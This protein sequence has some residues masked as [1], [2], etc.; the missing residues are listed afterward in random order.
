MIFKKLADTCREYENLKLDQKQ[1]I[2]NHEP[3][4]NEYYNGSS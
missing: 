1:D 2:S 4:S 3:T